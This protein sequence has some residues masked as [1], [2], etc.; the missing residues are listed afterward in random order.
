MK[1]FRNGH[2]WPVSSPPIP[3]GIVVV[4]GSKI[5]AVG[6][7]GLSYKENAEVIDCGGKHVMPGLVEAHSHLTLFDDGLD[8]LF[9]KQVKQEVMGYK[10]KYGG[11][12][13]PDWDVYYD[14]CH[15][16]PELKEALRG[17]V[18]TALIRPGSTRVI[19]GL[20]FVTKTLG[21]SRKDMVIKRP[22]GL[23]IAFGENPISKEYPATRMA[24]AAVLRESLIAAGNYKGK[25]RDLGLEILRDLLEGKLTA[26]VHAHRHDDIMTVIRLVDE[27]GFSLVLE[28]ATEAYKVVDEIVKRDIPCVTG[29]SF[30][31]RDKVELR[32]ETFANPGILERAGVK[33]AITTDHP[34]VG[35]EYLRLEAILAYREGLSRDGA[36][37]AITLWPAE[38]I[39]V[40]DRVGSIEVSKDADLVILNGDPLSLISR[41][42][43]V[44][45]NGEKAY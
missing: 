27:F 41:V 8:V 26:K 33:L 17:G 22:D 4:D 11:S 3:D 5:V 39:G 38:I 21:T 43:Q 32:D 2:I 25:E 6:D 16:H 18:T 45:V 35:I 29:P 12:V 42:D 37:K 30:A 20:G 1:V 13:T 31:S 44:Y 23:K 7:K 40:S 24:N 9:K 36:L 15:D 14:F 19:N 10:R 34:I 28:H